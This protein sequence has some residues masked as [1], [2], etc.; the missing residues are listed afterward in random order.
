MFAWWGCICLIPWRY[1]VLNVSEIPN[2]SKKDF[3]TLV[4]NQA[5]RKYV[6]LQGASKEVKI[7]GG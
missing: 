2:P 7:L 6:T 5:W 4:K 3:T 1:E